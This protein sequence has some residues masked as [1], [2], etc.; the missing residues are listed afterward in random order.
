MD[1]ANTGEKYFIRYHVV[2]NKVVTD[3]REFDSF[4]EAVSLI[5]KGL[6]NEVVGIVKNGGY[7]IEIQTKHI[8]YHEVMN[9]TEFKKQREWN[10]LN[11]LMQTALNKD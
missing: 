1:M 2:G 10:H 3:I 6:K 8:I 7:V 4:G 5:S 9:G 11:N